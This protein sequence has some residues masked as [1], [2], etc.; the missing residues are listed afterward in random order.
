[1]ATKLLTEAQV[2]EACERADKGD[3]MHSLAV[4]ELTEFLN[5]I[6]AAKCEY[7][8]QLEQR[9]THIENHL[10]EKFGELP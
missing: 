3:A 9:V 5:A 2:R 4:S 7:Y 8:K 1:M 6:L 10:H